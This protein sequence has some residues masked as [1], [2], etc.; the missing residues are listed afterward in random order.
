L[1]ALQTRIQGYSSNS[2][3]LNEDQK[4]AVNTLPV[5]E[6]VQKELAEVKKAVEVIRIHLTR[7][8]HIFAELTDARCKN[9]NSHTTFELNERRP[10]EPLLTK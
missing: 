1:Y 6:A 7:T 2:A 4:R 9:W 8:L 3:E 10:S 5:L